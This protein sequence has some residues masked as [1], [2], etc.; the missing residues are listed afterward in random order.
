M[1][2]DEVSLDVGE[3]ATLNVY[4]FIPSTAQDGEVDA[5]TFR[6]TSHLRADVAATAQLSTMAFY[7]RI[8]R[9]NPATASDIGDLGDVIAYEMTLWNYSMVTDTIEL[10]SVSGWEMHMSQTI[11]T[12]GSY[13]SVRVTVYVHVPFA[14]APGDIDIQDLIATSQ[15]DPTAH[16]V[17]RM[18]SHAGIMHLRLP[19][20]L[21]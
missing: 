7:P 3:S 15:S 13:E 11:F 8:V 12:L 21:R 20:L 6:A 18:T 2:D 5:L 14:A 9:L 16:D 4:V 1:L 10:T 17:S 19:L